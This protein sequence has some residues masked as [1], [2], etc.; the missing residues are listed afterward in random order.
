M[1]KKL[2]NDPARVVRESLEG[3]VLSR[4]GIALL[5]AG[6]TVVRADRVLGTEST[7]SDARA[8][9]RWL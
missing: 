8:P 7:R 2:I 1:A 6:L 4:P 9:S 3:V 5:G